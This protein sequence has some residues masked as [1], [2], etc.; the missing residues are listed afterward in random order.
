MVEKHTGPTSM[1]DYARREGYK[2]S[3]MY[4]PEQKGPINSEVFIDNL[5]ASPVD[6]ANRPSPENPN[7]I[8]LV[9]DKGSPAGPLTL[10]IEVNGPQAADLIS[11]IE[12]RLSSTAS[13]PNTPSAADSFTVVRSLP[14]SGNMIVSAN[15]PSMDYTLIA[16]VVDE[17]NGTMRGFV[18]DRDNGIK[19]K[20]ADDVNHELDTDDVRKALASAYKR[21]G[22]ESAARNGGYAGAASG[23]N[24]GGSVGGG[25]GPR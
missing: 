8:R 9:A 1:E 20:R 16:K 14:S 6:P 24:T 5:Y 12:K 13:G 4:T 22:R 3:K 19:E 11:R 25:F 17:I 10:L 18:I 15:E 7:T 23:G 2:P 21:Y